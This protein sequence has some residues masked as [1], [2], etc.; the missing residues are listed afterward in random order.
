MDMRKMKGST[1]M[2]SLYHLRDNYVNSKYK[3]TLPYEALVS[4]RR[5]FVRLAL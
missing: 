5:V 3:A 2:R 1:C 4:I